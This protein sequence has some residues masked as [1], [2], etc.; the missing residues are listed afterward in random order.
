M[1]T[2]LVGIREFL[3]AAVGL[4][5]S[6][7]PVVRA[8]LLAWLLAVSVTQPMKFLL[9]LS[10][11][12]EKRH[13]CAQVVAFVTGFLG[14]VLFAELPLALRCALGLLVGLWAPVAY[15]LFVRAIEDRW[16]RLADALSGDVRGVLLGEPRGAQLP[17]PLPPRD[18]LP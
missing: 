12:P 13:L 8:V 9:P 1:D 17:R 10:W 3:A 18:A 7:P 6:V 5:D 4:Y 15:F 16:P 11:T 14:V 2:V